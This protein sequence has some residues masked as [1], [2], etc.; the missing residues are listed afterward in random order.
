MKKV[1]QMI[2][3]YPTNMLLDKFLLPSQIQ[4]FFEE[5][6]APTSSYFFRFFA[7]EA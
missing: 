6:Q 1:I 7:E 2:Q 5:T 4:T 3:P